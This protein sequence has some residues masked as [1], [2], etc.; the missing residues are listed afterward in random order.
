MMGNP[1]TGMQELTSAGVSVTQVITLWLHIC[2]IKEHGNWLS[3]IWVIFPTLVLDFLVGFWDMDL[4]FGSMGEKLQNTWNTVFFLS[5]MMLSL[6][7]S[8][9]GEHKNKTQTP[10]SWWPDSGRWGENGQK[11][12]P[13]S[14]PSWIFTEI[15]VL[16]C[17]QNKPNEDPLTQTEFLWAALQTVQIMCIL[18]LKTAVIL[19]VLWFFLM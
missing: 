16:L 5:K 6:G 14:L 1:E 4:F 19:A 3:Q 10:L 17:S 11:W 2:W 12:G 9:G 7:L 15:L 18:K 13:G 8:S